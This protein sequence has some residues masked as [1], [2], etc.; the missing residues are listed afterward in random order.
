MGDSLASAAADLRARVGRPSLAAL[1]QRSGLAKGT[2]IDLLEGRRRAQWRTV[3]AFVRACRAYPYDPADREL[4]EERRWLALFE[5]AERSARHLIG[6]VP[7]LA[8][9]YVP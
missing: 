2:L 5:G 4:F 8:D 6:P 7:A 3:E 9:A 1:A